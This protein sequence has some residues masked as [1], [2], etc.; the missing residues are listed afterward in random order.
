VTRFQPG[1]EVFGIGKGAFAGGRG[2]QRYDVI[3]DIG[4]NPSLSRLRRALT[5]KGTL[6]ITV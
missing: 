6:V 1:D 2:E 4:G 3:L 5:P